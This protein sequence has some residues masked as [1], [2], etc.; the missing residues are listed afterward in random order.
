MWQQNDMIH[1][2]S[3]PGIER[4]NILFMALSMA[5]EQPLYRAVQRP[6]RR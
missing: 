4:Q 5:Q 2:I 1:T 6:L 3:F